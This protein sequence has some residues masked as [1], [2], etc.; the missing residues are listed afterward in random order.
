MFS[1]IAE[2]DVGR[3]ARGRSPDK[4]RC[5]LRVCEYQLAP[6]AEPEGHNADKGSRD[7][8]INFMRNREV[9][10]GLHAGNLPGLAP[11]CRPLAFTL[12]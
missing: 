9:D 11:S 3:A 4:L 6:R 10:A 5:A 8:S 2:V 12:R 1:Y 7:L